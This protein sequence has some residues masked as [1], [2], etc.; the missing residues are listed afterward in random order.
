M[1]SIVG[2]DEVATG[3]PPIQNPFNNDYY[4]QDHAAD[5]NIILR[6]KKGD[7]SVEVELPGD[8][9]QMS[10][11]VVPMSPEFKNQSGNEGDSNGLDTRYTTQRP[12]MTDREI[13]SSL[14][15]SPDLDG[16]RQTIE[17]GLGVTPAA[18]S[19]PDTDR[20]YLAGVDRIKQ[21]FKLGR[22]EAALLETDGLLRLYPTDAKLYQ[23]RG[24]L[25]DRTGRNDMAIRSWQ[26]ALRFDPNNVSLKRLVDRQLARRNTPLS[27]Q[28]EKKSP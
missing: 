10:D 27:N 2:A 21:L 9:N 13:A 24:T 8:A 15:Q 1:K 14:P 11:F 26:Q 5:N 4:S 25:L 18:D 16:R 20:S 28:L 23:M 22:Y 17:A 19:L 3:T 6:S 12:T 7:R